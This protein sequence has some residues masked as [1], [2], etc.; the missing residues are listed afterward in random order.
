MESKKKIDSMVANAL[1][2]GAM[3][4][5]EP[6]D[7]GYMYTQSIEDLDGHIWEFI[8]MNERKMTAELK[9]LKEKK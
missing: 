8:W 6:K 3:R 2:A 5:R 9:K 4:I 1:K 7:N